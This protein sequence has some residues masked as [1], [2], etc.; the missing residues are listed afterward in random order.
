MSEQL[1]NKILDKL[2]AV[3]DK[4]QSIENSLQV[5]NNRLEDFQSET[6]VHFSEIKKMISE[7]QIENIESDNRL[8][9]A[10]HTTNDRLD[11]QRNKISKTEEDLYL[12]K[13]K[14]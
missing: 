12:L 14:H 10:I 4:V 3:E 8:L 1:L 13:Q 7:N 2:Q 11:F 6:S 5:T 9:A